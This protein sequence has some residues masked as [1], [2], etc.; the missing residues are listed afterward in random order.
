MNKFLKPAALVVINALVGFGY[1][2]NTFAQ[3]ETETQP[4]ES[5]LQQKDRYFPSG[6]LRLNSDFPSTYNGHSA[7]TNV[8]NFLN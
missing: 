1:T 4:R 5:R 2:A 3:E 8:L 6:D 7:G